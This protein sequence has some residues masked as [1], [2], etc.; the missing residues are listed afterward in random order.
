MLKSLSL[1][2]KVLSYLSYLSLPPS[3]PLSLCLSPLPPSLSFYLSPS[4]PP[5]LSLSLSPPPSLPPIPPPPPFVGFNPIVRAS[6]R[7]CPLLVLVWWI[8]YLVLRRRRTNQSTMSY[9][10]TRVKDSTASGKRSQQKQKADIPPVLITFRLDSA[11]LLLLAFLTERG[12]CFSKKPSRRKAI[13]KIRVAYK[14]MYLS[15]ILFQILPAAR[16]KTGH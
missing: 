16:N 4:L 9:R 6:P 1:C 13:Y 2:N 3:L 8:R 14:I 7:P 11:T 10:R 5:S 12:P 15:F